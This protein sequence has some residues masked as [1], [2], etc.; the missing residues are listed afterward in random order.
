MLLHEQKG[1]PFAASWNLHKVP[2]LEIDKTKLILIK[3]I[4]IW[5]QKNKK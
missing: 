1:F 4:G 3:F 5:A 2:F